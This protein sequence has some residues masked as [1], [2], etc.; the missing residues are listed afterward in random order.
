MRAPLAAL[1]LCATVAA[2]DLLE[3]V[4]EIGVP[5]VP[6]VLSLWGDAKCV[7]AVP[8]GP[9]LATTT[10]GRGRIAVFSHGF[11][12]VMKDGQT[13]RLMRNLF[14]WAGRKPKR[15]GIQKSKPLM[16]LFGE[17]AVALKGEW[18][19]ELNKLDVIL[20]GVTAL[21]EQQ[22]KAVR[23]YIRAGGGL[24]CGH[25][26]WGWQQLNAGKDLATENVGN[27]LL[28]PAGIVFGQNWIRVPKNK[29]IKAT[30]P[31]PM[32]HAGHAFA[33]L[34]ADGRM[35]KQERALAVNTLSR[36]VREAPPHDKL[37]LPQL[38]KLLTKNSPIPPIS[39]N[40]GLDKVLL[41]M[42]LREMRGRKAEDVEAHPAAAQFP[43]AVPKKAR[44]VWRK[45]EIDTAVPGWHSTGLYAA[46]GEVVRVKGD[47]KLR[48]R[49]GCHKDRLWNKSKW[50]RAPEITR[51]FP[52][53][54]R[55]KPTAA[56][57]SFGGPI[58]VVVPP[59]CRLGRVSVEIA[60]AVEAPLY[61]HG[62]T[63]LKEW[64]EKIRHRPGPWAELA[65]DKV[66]ITVPSKVVR[67]VENPHELMVFWNEVMDAC[68]DLAARPHE[69]N[70]P[71]RYVADE[72]ISAGYMHAGYPIMTHLDAAPRFVN[73]EHLKT[74][75]D[76]GMFHEMGHNHQHKDWTFGGTGEVTCNLFSLYVLETCC[77]GATGHKA[78][79]PEAMANRIKKYKGNGSKFEQWK[80]E[81]FLALIMYRQLQQ[82]FGW[83]AYKKVFAEYRDLANDQRPKNDDQKR[84]QWMVRFSRM[85]GKNLG[86]FF[87]SWGVPTSKEARDSIADLPVWMPE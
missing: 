66:I 29:R 17:S 73:L 27:R 55:E 60:G 85:V 48:I 13:E 51:E 32:H 81:P 86:P 21:N 71:E 41:A 36:F 5:G 39:P 8:A 57:C 61:V 50:R 83:E 22:L 31:S 80:R 25:P 59:R 69:R 65:T 46:P 24:V 35:T 37:L 16:N 3:G 1:L 58:Y 44:R 9:V 87:E 4:K 26:G 23:R 68:A 7:I 75:G 47:E 77:P 79:S 20:V 2:Q 19:K 52:I 53:E 63:D 30:P 82:A 72:Q 74:K 67:G 10:L 11:W 45:L 6:G 54:K 64:R 49:I 40:Q 14:D 76:W 56:A 78:T 84:D 70:R 33:T 38:R 62:K 15:V 34:Q 43:G 12:S 42:Q 18:T 28:A